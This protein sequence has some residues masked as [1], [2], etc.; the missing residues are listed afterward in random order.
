V[1]CPKCDDTGRILVIDDPAEYYD[2]PEGITAEELE[3]DDLLRHDL[4]DCEAGAAEGE[5]D[6]ATLEVLAEC[7]LDGKALTD[8]P[9]PPFR[10]CDYFDMDK[11]AEFLEREG[12]GKGEGD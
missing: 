12:G 8:L 1:N 2:N 3:E 4:C 5:K 7:L 6:D 9:E 11:Y 10:L